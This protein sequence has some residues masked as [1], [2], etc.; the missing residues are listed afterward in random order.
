VAFLW[1]VGYIASIRGSACRPLILY[2]YFAA[3]VLVLDLVSKI[4]NLHDTG[5]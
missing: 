1:Y 4:S 3:C 2:L 5:F